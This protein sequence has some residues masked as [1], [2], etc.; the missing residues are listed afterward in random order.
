MKSIKTKITA[1]VL[2]C[3]VFSSVSVGVAGML[4]S[5]SAVAA[6][7]VQIMNLLCENRAEEL[8]ALLK[9]IEQSV[10][11]L[12]LYASYQMEDVGRFKTDAEY[13]DEYAASLLDIALNAGQSTEGAL[14]V[15]LRFN[16]EFTS[17]TSG[18]FCGRQVRSGAFQELPPTDLSRYDPSDIE[19]VGWY[20]IPVSSGKGAWMAPYFNDNIGVEM[21]SYVVP[22]YAGGTL[23][24]VVG[25]DIDFNMLAQVVD[26][27]SIYRTGYTFLTNKNAEIEAHKTLP[28]STD[29]ANFNNGEFRETAQLLKNGSSNGGK[30][31]SYTYEGEEKR[32]AFRLLDNGMR[33]VLTAPG[34][35]IDE[36]ADQ[37]MVQLL[38]AIL[39][40]ALAAATISVAYAVKLVKPLVELTGAAK[41]IAEGDLSVSITHQSNDEVGALAESFRQTVAHLHKYISYINELAYRDP[42]TGVKN[43]TAY[44]E[45]VKRLE[46]DARIRR[47]QYAVLVFD[48]NG[49][50]EVNDTRGHDFGDMLIIGACK[51]ICGVFKRSPVY[52]IGGD[53]FVALLEERDYDRYPELLDELQAAFNAYNADAH[54]EIKI[55]VARGIAIYSEETDLTYNDVFKRADNAMYHNKLEMK[56]TMES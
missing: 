11:T 33:L 20:Y 43:K 44:L 31:I 45:N 30:L 13:V 32:A 51:I 23:I 25:M 8:N 56:K 46:E 19:H 50:K 16:P 5:R 24:G 37:L 27:T 28:R 53:E 39:I 9:R 48:I 22:L 2:C 54:N 21:V 6:D 10:E 38:V 14:T 52:R 34:S 41:K 36:Q 4:H 35:E 17:P 3:V 15:Y 47:V 12:T 29:L 7:S 26:N 42:L 40:V 55:S 18:F 1:L 49:L